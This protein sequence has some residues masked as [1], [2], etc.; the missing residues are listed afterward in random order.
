MLNCAAADFLHAIE[1]IHGHLL[2][3]EVEPFE[4]GIGRLFQIRI[5]EKDKIAFGLPHS[6]EQRRLVAEIP[7]EL[8]ESYALVGF[9]DLPAHAH[10]VIGASIIHDNDFPRTVDLFQ[11]SRHCMEECCDAALGIV[12]GGGHRNNRSLHAYPPYGDLAGFL[13]QISLYWS[14]NGKAKT[15]DAWIG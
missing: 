9:D 7:R 6:F 5:D 8:D 12:H 15:V 13:P 14:S 4:Q 2:P 10:A 3:E 1:H 11:N